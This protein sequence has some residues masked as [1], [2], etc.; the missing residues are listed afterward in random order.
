MPDNDIPNPFAAGE[1]FTRMWLDLANRMMSAGTSVQPGATP[2]DM[3]RDVRNAMMR[4]WAEA[5]DGYMRSPEFLEMMRQSL[6]GAVQFRQA[7]NE[8]LGQWQHE[9]QSVS[10]QD[11]DQ[12][13][14]LLRRLD[15]RVDDLQT[16]LARVE[17]AVERLE[18]EVAELGRRRSAR[19]KDE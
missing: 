2:P 12:V 8:M 6:A 15:G 3:A 1:A 17:V 5:L 9:L 19:R 11:I 7:A 10:R 13:I 16:R 4:A 14:H 18:S